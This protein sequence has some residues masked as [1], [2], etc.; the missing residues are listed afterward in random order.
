M[1]ATKPNLYFKECSVIKKKAFEKIFLH[2][3]LLLNYNNYQSISEINY[4]HYF[5]IYEGYFNSFIPSH[6]MHLFIDRL[7]FALGILR[8]KN[9]ILKRIMK[10]DL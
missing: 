5:E 2:L 8:E 3:F 7:K 9:F 6:A 1:I 10:H 4:R